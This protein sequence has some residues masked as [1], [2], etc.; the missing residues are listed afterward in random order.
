MELAS[1]DELREKL[2]HYDKRERRRAVNL[3]GMH[4]DQ[5]AVLLLQWVRDD[6]LQDS[7]ARR[8]AKQLL[9]A[10]AK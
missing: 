3:I 7:V 9:A 6:P 4:C 10:K 2:T 8:R 5:G 1:L